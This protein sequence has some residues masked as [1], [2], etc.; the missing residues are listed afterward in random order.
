MKLTREQFISQFPSEVHP[1]DIV[2]WMQADI[3]HKAEGDSDPFGGVEVFRAL[4]RLLIK[5]DNQ[6]YITGR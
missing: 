2:D 3:L 6:F 5:V 4:D 1:A